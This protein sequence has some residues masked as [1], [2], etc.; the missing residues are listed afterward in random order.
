VL[1]DGF[2]IEQNRAPLNAANMDVLYCGSPVTLPALLHGKWRRRV[3]VTITLRRYVS[4]KY[5][6]RTLVEADATVNAEVF[7][8]TIK[9]GDAS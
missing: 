9:A 8:D 2:R 3:D 1:R 4:R 5:N 7:V 6:I